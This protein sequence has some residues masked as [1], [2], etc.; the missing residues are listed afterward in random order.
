MV[1]HLQGLAL[2]LAGRAFVGRERAVR[3][4]GTAGPARVVLEVVVGARL[5]GGHGVLGVELADR[6]PLAGSG[7]HPLCAGGARG[8]GSLVSLGADS[9]GGAVP[10]PTVACGGR[11]DRHFEPGGAVVVRGARAPVGGGGVLARLAV[12]AH[13]CSGVVAT[14]LDVAAGSADWLLL[15]R[16]DAVVA[17]VVVVSCAAGCAGGT[18][19]AYPASTT[20]MHDRK[21]KQSKRAQWNGREQ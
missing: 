5:A 6:A 16:V 18:A 4:F 9:P 13:N 19:V 12:G 10:A 1:S 3:T 8:A 14:H 7:G 15:A 11:R 17:F 21:I 2:A 20:C